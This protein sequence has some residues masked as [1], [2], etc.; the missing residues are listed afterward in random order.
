MS[1]NDILNLFQQKY[2]RAYIYADEYSKLVSKLGISLFMDLRSFCKKEGDSDI[3]T[4]LIR[5]E[6]Y[7]DIEK[8]MRP[9]TCSFDPENEIDAVASQILEEYPLIGEA[10]LSEETRKR[11]FDRAQQV[12]D[13]ILEYSDKDLT[14]AE[15]DVMTLAIVQHLKRRSI[16]ETDKDEGQIWSYIFN[17]FGFK[18]EQENE[19]QRI[20]NVL[21]RV[22]RGSILQH[23]RFF[24]EEENTQRYYNT[25][26]LHAMAPVKSMESL[27]EILLSFY[28]HDLEFNYIQ[29]DRAFSA[30][31]KCIAYRWDHDIEVQE[32]LNV[33][34]NPMASGLRTLFT[35]RP[36]FMRDYCERIVRAIDALIRGN[37]AVLQK[38]STLDLLLYNWYARKDGY[39]R[40]DLQ[41]SRQS[42]G[43][44][45]RNITSA[46][47]LRIRYVLEKGRV[48]LLIPSVRLEEKADNYPEIRIYQRDVCVFSRTMEVFG[49]YSWT[50]HAMKIA[51][52]D[53]DID[54]YVS[55]ELS[56]QIE[57][58]TESEKTTIVNTQSKLYRK[59]IL[60]D[61]NG[62]EA[63]AQNSLHGMYYLFATEGARIEVEET[64]I[65]WLDHGGQL[66]RLYIDNETSVCVDDEELA[67]SPERKD[68]VRF[69][70]SVPVSEHLSGV[71]EGY[72]IAIYP[73]A[74]S[75]TIRIPEENNSLS[76]RIE[77]DGN[78]EPLVR[79]CPSGK[80]SFVL[81]PPSDPAKKHS[82]RIVDFETGRIAGALRY[83][84]LPGVKVKTD[85]KIIYEDGKPVRV[86]VTYDGCLI[87]TTAMPEANSNSVTVSADHLAFDLKAEIPLIYGNLGE[88]NIFDLDAIIWHERIPD[89]SFS[90]I[91]CPDGWQCHLKLGEK[92]IPQNTINGSYE[93]GNLIRSFSS[94]HTA[95]LLTLV[96]R[97]P[98][99]IQDMQ[100]L[101]RI[102]FEEYFTESP[103]SVENQ[104]LMWKPTQK[105]I[106]GEKDEFL[107]YIDVP[108]DNSPYTYALNTKDAVASKLFFQDFP[109][110][111]F[112][113]RIMKCSK[114]LFSGKK[115]RL[116]HEGV[117]TVGEPE[118]WALDGKALYLDRARCWD[119]NT[120]KHVNIDLP[121]SAGC[122]IDFKYIGYSIPAG[123]DISYPEYEAT[124]Y[125][126]DLRSERW[127]PFS[128]SDRGDYERIN[129]VHIWIVSPKL[130]ILATVDGEAVML[131]RNYN[132]IVNRSLE[133]PREIERV[134]I[135]IPDYFEYSEE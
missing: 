15:R 65:S 10:V 13:E 22:I 130:L 48:C 25:L 92:N 16:Q 7:K 2:G 69:Y 50:T 131:D 59:Y 135:I 14:E 3:R 103:V 60:F 118:Q 128:S 45:E 98:D 116:L 93:I 1:E 63:V 120:N 27:F 79:Y 76:Y 84:V 12:F 56:V 47:S 33:R 101:T 20:Y 11:L 73:K 19:R 72:S 110:G 127:I 38:Q 34:S 24:S 17:Q 107:L 57:Y 53:T 115:E 88:W 123:E 80:H 75:L 85:R 23:D 99:G 91:Y 55:P 114:G 58:P 106:G 31:R 9:G 29:G 39:I 124:L 119:M 43:T 52:E 61:Q 46:E 62:Q 105:Y 100:V 44:A 51:L 132:S 90:K 42:A 71:Y 129:P 134:R 113:Y 78:V 86:Y 112:P 83:A 126:Y 125:F 81:N 32:D 26:N 21:R 64:N 102:V 70:S 117:L 77:I 54:F 37:D 97:T 104:L 68:S 94:A 89:T 6:M 122:L 66:A 74:F 95:E 109:Y 96:V 133:L 30:I 8:D 121:K 40:D 108:L 111:V 87:Q 4:W 5:H 67:V 28:I 36:C 82:V 41:R 18:A 35:A 49:R